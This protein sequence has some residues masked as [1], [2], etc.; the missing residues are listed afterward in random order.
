MKY[1]E[2]SFRSFVQFWKGVHL[3]SGDGASSCV[4]DNA[5]P[6]ERLG[7]GH[8]LC[9]GVTAQRFLT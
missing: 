3:S 9:V 5:I 1:V 6:R 2:S 8:P 4:G 7:V